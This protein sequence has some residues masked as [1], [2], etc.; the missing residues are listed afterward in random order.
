MNKYLHSLHKKPEHH[1]KRFAL[2]ASGTITLFIFGI[3]SFVNF[4][5]Q[6]NQLVS[7]SE[8]DTSKVIE[9]SPLQSMR[10]NLASSLEALL[11]SLRGLKSGIESLDFKSSYAEIKDNALDIYGQ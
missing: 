11:E 10:L 7:K 4:A 8:R 3:W 1:K 5:P 9:I 6:S 2:L